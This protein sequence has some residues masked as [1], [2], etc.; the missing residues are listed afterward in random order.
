M[1]WNSKIPIKIHI[2]AKMYA[3]D[4]NTRKLIKKPEKDKMSK[5]SHKGWE[6]VF[7][8]TLV[9]NPNPPSSIVSSIFTS[10][11]PRTFSLVLTRFI[12]GSAPEALALKAPV[13]LFMCS[14]ESDS[15]YMCC[16]SATLAV[17]SSANVTTSNS[18]V[19]QKMSSQSKALIK[20]DVKTLVFST[21]HNLH[22]KC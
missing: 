19:L 10:F 18:H 11:M 6:A 2:C 13:T 1:G 20:S 22:R 21:Y 7:Y 17:W 16:R 9:W 5:R 8:C 12:P 14:V 4:N 15:C 3:A